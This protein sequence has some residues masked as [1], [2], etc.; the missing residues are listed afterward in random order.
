MFNNTSQVVKKFN[1][2]LHLTTLF[3]IAFLHA[4]HRYSAYSSFMS[5]ITA[6]KQSVIYDPLSHVST[7]V[8]T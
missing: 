3:F 2:N 4:E 7:L 5:I 1:T 8:S 6:R